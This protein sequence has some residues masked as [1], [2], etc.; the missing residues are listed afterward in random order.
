MVRA[1]PGSASFVAHEAVKHDPE[2]QLHFPFSL[3]LLDFGGSRFYDE[4]ISRKVAG[5]KGFN[6]LHAL[7]RAFYS[8]V[9]GINGLELLDN[10]STALPD[11]TAIPTT[12]RSL[13]RVLAHLLESSSHEKTLTKQALAEAELLIAAVNQA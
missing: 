3:T 6:D 5:N 12:M 4:Q 8:Q 11:G 10:G 2:L 1:L 13:Q 7:C 9:Y